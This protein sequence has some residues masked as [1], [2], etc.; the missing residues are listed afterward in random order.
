[1]IFIRKFRTA[2]IAVRNEIE[3]R[4]VILEGYHKM[5]WNEIERMRMYHEHFTEKN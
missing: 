2:D 3:N 4:N 1:M 5:V